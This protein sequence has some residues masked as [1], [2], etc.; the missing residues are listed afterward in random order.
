MVELG[1]L[2]QSSYFCQDDAHTQN[3]GYIGWCI[4]N[5]KEE[6]YSKFKYFSCQKFSHCALHCPQ[7][8]RTGKHHASTII[9]DPLH[10]QTKLDKIADDP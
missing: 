9:V 10:K 4:S 5:S 8:K 3:S 2:D 7:K 1:F 6:G